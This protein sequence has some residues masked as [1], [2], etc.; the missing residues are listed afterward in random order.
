MTLCL[1][2]GLGFPLL[3]AGA[4]LGGVA[5]PELRGFGGFFIGISSL[6][7]ALGRISPFPAEDFPAGLALC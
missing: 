3:A 7:L 1:V 6:F 5:A 4:V 2:V